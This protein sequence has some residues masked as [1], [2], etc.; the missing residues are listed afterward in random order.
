[1][2]CI[3]I[4]DFKG[5]YTWGGLIILFLLEFFFKERITYYFTS[6]YEYYELFYLYLFQTFFIELFFQMLLII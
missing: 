4:R 6:Y 5:I 2:R 3:K 1:M